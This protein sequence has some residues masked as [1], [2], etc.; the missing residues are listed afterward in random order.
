MFHF[1]S[2]KPTPLTRT[3]KPVP[4][5]FLG[6]PI[7][8]T[9]AQPIDAVKSTTSVTHDECQESNPIPR[10]CVESRGR[11]HAQGQ[12]VLSIYRSVNAKYI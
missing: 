9:P 4:R 2:I 8:P 12:P 6:A 11:T 7:Y 5:I 3:G 10:R 1:F